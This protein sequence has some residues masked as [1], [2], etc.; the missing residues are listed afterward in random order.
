NA[1]SMGAALGREVVEFGRAAS[2]LRIFVLYSSAGVS[3]DRS[4]TVLETELLHEQSFSR[5]FEQ[6]LALMERVV[7]RAS[8]ELPVVVVRPTTLTGDSQ[9]GECER[10][11]PLHR[12][13]E[14]IL[15]LP[16]QQTLRV[17]RERSPLHLVPVDYVA[18]VAYY[19]GRRTDSAG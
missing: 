13:V 6:A 3:G 16:A 10:T 19:L 1:L 7:R 11:G 5:P 15:A 17:P 2:R 9:T 8:A 4:G 12:L 14:T 18:R